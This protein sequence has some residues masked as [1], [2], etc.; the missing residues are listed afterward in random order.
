M[1]DLS[2]LNIDGILYSAAKRLREKC[3][4]ELAT[5]WNEKSIRAKLMGGT[6]PEETTR[7]LL[8]KSTIE[9]LD[10]R[11]SQLSKDETERRKAK[12]EALQK[13]WAEEDRKAASNPPI[14]GPRFLSEGTLIEIDGHSWKVISYDPEGDLVVEVLK[15]PDDKYWLK[16]LEEGKRY[17]LFEHKHN[18]KAKDSPGEFMEIWEIPGEQMNRSVSQALLYLWEEGPSIGL[19][20]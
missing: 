2:K 7:Q 8:L 6:H 17:T 20:F 12:R 3:H 9:K 5:T 15:I 19:D 4:V 10:R 16:Y 13:K 1:K 11:I 14:L 18:R